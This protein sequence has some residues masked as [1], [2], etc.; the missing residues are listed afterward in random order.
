MI[1]RIFGN[2]QFKLLLKNLL[3]TIHND[4][5]ERRCKK[6]PLYSL[7]LLDLFQCLEKLPILLFHWKYALRWLLQGKYRFFSVEVSVDSVERDSFYLHKILA[8]LQFQFYVNFSSQLQNL[9][10]LPCQKLQPQRLQ[11]LLVVEKTVRG[12]QRAWEDKVRRKSW[13]VVAIKILQAESIQQNLQKK[14]VGREESFLQMFL[15]NLVIKTPIPLSCDIFWKSWRKM[16]FVHNVLSS[17]EREFYPTNTLDEN[18]IWFKNS[19]GSDSSPWFKRVL[20]GSEIQYHLRS[21]LQNLQY[22]VS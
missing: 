13:A 10:V 22:Q 8:K 4:S 18:C 19:N 2:P 21:W 14:W 6:V 17:L 11:R 1:Y 20:L 9:W 3:H 16:F 7:A 5:R 12:Q 15:T